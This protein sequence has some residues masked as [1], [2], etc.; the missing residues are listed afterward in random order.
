MTS[1][2]PTPSPSL[3]AGHPELAHL[4]IVAHHLDVLTSVITQ[5]HRGAQQPGPLTHQARSIVLVIRV[6]QLQA[7]AY[8]RMAGV[9][10]QRER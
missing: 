9:F 2:A 8:C 3:Q 6:L 10:D 7:D 5:V 4:A 1:V